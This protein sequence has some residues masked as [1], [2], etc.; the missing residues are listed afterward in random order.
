MQRI[1]KRLE[2]RPFSPPPGGKGHQGTRARKMVYRQHVELRL[3]VA[4]HGRERKRE[5]ELRDHQEMWSGGQLSSDYAIWTEH[6]ITGEPF[7]RVPR[8]QI[9]SHDGMTFGKILH[10][11]NSTLGQ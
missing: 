5:R 1:M 9:V 7:W 2:L 6:S 4:E 8:I 11:F 10:L 3:L